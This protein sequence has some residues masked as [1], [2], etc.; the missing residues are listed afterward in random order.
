MIN[1]R[2]QSGRHKE[3]TPIALLV[4]KKRNKKILVARNKAFC[5]GI[6]DTLSFLNIDM[7]LEEDLRNIAAIFNRID[8]GVIIYDDD[9]YRIVSSDKR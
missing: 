4:I 1:T 2:G 9:A 3:R 7:N 6:K 5:P 8:V